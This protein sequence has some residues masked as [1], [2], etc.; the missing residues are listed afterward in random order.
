MIKTIHLALCDTSFPDRKQ[1]ER[2]LSRESDKRHEECVIYMDTFGSK[3][4]LLQNPRTY[5][6]YF[7]DVPNEEYS[8]YDLAV[9]L[10]NKGIISPIV[11][12]VS[13]MNYRESGPLL[14]NSVFINKPLKVNELSLVVDEI[15]LQKEEHT[16]PTIEFRNPTEVYYLEPKDIMYI[17]EAGNNRFFHIHLNDNSVMEAQGFIDSAF[18]EFHAYP[19]FFM[20]SKKCI[21]NAT[22]I[23]KVSLKK[24]TLQNDTEIPIPLGVSKKINQ[25]LS[26][27]K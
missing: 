15:L 14:D 8:A 11:F 2:L 27:L 21:I 6:A 16:I 22:Y 1:L 5:D 20:P 10:Q 7:L 19:S 25:L 24:V 12:C 4:T 17:D 18:S 9:E 26:T 23:K 13:T 3:E